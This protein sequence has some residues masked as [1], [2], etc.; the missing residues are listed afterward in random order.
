M[1]IIFFG[2]IPLK[3]LYDYF[4]YFLSL[5][6]WKYDV[7]EGKVRPRLQWAQTDKSLQ[8]QSHLDYLYINQMQF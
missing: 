6:V 8:V 7:A 3:R 5:E 4:L 2:C 1:K